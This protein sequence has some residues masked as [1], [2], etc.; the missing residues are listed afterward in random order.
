M[1]NAA[2]KRGLLAQLDTAMAD[3]RAVRFGWT[4]D[5]K[6]FLGQVQ[7]ARRRRSVDAT[8]TARF[9][10]TAGKGLL[11]ALVIGSAVTVGGPA[12][13]SANPGDT[14]TA[15]DNPQAASPPGGAAPTS[16]AANRRAPA[17]VARAGSAGAHSDSTPSGKR[18]GPLLAESWVTVAAPRRRTG[19]H[20][21]AMPV[22]AAA[23]PAGAVLVP[24]N[25]RQ[26]A[27]PT[28]GE[29]FRY[30]FSH[31]SPTAAPVQNPGQ[32]T[33]GVV[34][35]NLNAR[36]GIGA[37]LT[38]TLAVTPASGSVV[39][40]GDGSYVY[41]PDATL[42]LAGGSDTFKVT[43]DDG[44]AYRRTGIGGV[45]TN[46]FLSLAR[47][48]GSREPD[49]ITVT[50]PVTIVGMSP[51]PPNSAPVM[52]TPA[53]GVPNGVT[54][55]VTGWVSAVDADGETLRYSG[56]TT[57]SRGSV[58]V[59][60]A[61]AFTYTP[62]QSARQAA[63]G[64]TTDT[65]TVTV[66]DGFATDAVTVVVPVDPGT[67]I[68]GTTVVGR[69][70]PST[71]A[72]SGVAVFTDTAGRVLTY[73]AP[74][75]SNGGGSLTIDSF[76][77]AFTY[78]PTPTQ[79]QATAGTDVFAVTASNGVRSATT[80]VNVVVSPATPPV[81]TAGTF[82]VSLVNGSAGAWR[83]D[84]IHV[85][86]LGQATP[87][88][89][90]WVDATG[91][92]RPLDHTAA[93][94]PGHL[95][96]DGVNYADM[97]FT[98][99]QAAGLSIPAELQGARMYISVG[100]PLY[101]GISPDDRGWAGPNPTNPADPNY[102]TVYD[103][104]ELSYAYGRTPYGGNTT[105]VDQFALPLTVTLEQS[106][107]G[108]SG[109]RG[110]A[111]TRD[112]VFARFAQTVPAEFQSLI[113]KDANGAP[114]RIVA[115]RTQQPAALA[116]WLDGPVNDFWTKY[117]AEP[118][119]YTGPGY[120]V[121][122]RVDANSQFAYTVTAAG[123][124]ATSYTMRKP[125]TAEIFACD[126]PFVGS[127]QQGAFLAE[128]SAAFNRGVASTP[129]EWNDVS[130]Y[131]PA[132][133]RW[134][135]Y[136]K[137]FHDIGVQNYAYGFPYDD[138][139]NQS[140][141]QILGNSNP[142]SRLTITVLAGVTP[143]ATTPPPS[144]SSLVVAEN[145]GSVS[146][147]SDPVTGLAYVQAAGSP[148]LPVT[149]ADSYWTGP[150]PLTRQGATMLAAER[151]SLGR[152]RVLD[153]SSYGQF[154]WILDENGRFSGEEQYTAST[155]PAAETLFGIDVNGDG[156][157]GPVP[158]EG[159]DPSLWTL[160]W[161]DEFNTPNTVPESAKW[162]YDLGGGGFGNAELQYYT[163]RPQNV[164]TDAD[165]HLVITAI[166]ENL[167]GSSCWY[168]SCRYT[169]GRILTKNTFTQ[170]YGR[171]EAS[172][173]LPA[174]QGMWPAFWMQGD[175]TGSAGTG[176]PARGEIDVMENIGREP[177]TVH[178]SLHG[179]G[180][181][182]GSAITGSYVLPAGQQFSDDFHTFA[183]EW[184]PNEIRWYVDGILYETRTRAD[185]P[186]G[187]PWVFDHP[188]Y[189]IL[190]SAV[191]GQWPGSPDSTTAFP[192]QMLIDYVRVYEPTAAL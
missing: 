142:P 97:S 17:S 105:Q 164:S 95:T 169:S 32:S 190:N 183:V 38:Y 172:I 150:V 72:I 79:R 188:F 123:G 31:K 111:L 126:G 130:A 176:W 66:D 74:P 137:F 106:G 40:G 92:V 43:V 189:L 136:A 45:I 21:I 180:Y 116:T 78:T 10:V 64:S 82:P 181:S 24:A 91:T 167:P 160:T 69:A 153:T 171:F 3:T 76:S 13:A 18:G 168:G 191:G 48:T 81:T 57:T 129:S 141:V 6:A 59:T 46:L 112:Q 29:I 62:T 147:L 143:V 73:S 37:A 54:G 144:T 109:T 114:L 121:T 192:Q 8:G 86:I 186:A 163:N 175:A 165:G 140:S 28:I 26:S 100:E 139:N 182:G 170:E 94:A 159:V 20:Q 49:T 124:G 39:L 5:V 70:D 50:V 87:G 166:Q 113:L 19:Q 88:V 174:G 102:T 51:P 127:G 55:V 133:Q 118:F 22:S 60:N 67:P 47:M 4:F 14:S 33:E 187:A 83:D 96:K 146:L 36:S 128:L 15:S 115:P 108:F 132:G 152:L 30:A 7:S 2:A 63:T 179:P 90:S 119:S 80:T 89:W 42:A 177:S 131:Y 58:I 84:Q 104:Y 9:G 101:I 61:G 99:A 44:S 125:T 148:A 162:S 107:S 185:L 145:Q 151:D 154:G 149:R 25:A 120:T 1:I 16:R 68:A 12:V 122:G 161:S 158:S 35:G 110:L 41:T 77:G 157:V 71:G 184:E 52:G 93:E 11:A 135:A 34:T 75:A 155:L 98:L 134:N 156:V 173:K 138:V 103:W 85:T 178:G 56:S 117:A 23:V 53:V 27:A 65:F